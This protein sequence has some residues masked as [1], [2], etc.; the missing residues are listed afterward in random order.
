MDAIAARL[1]G[2]AGA[3]GARG[4]IRVSPLAARAAIGMRGG[5]GE[6]ERCDGRRCEEKRPKSQKPGRP[7]RHAHI[8]AQP[9][10]RHDA[11]QSKSPIFAL[12]LSSNGQNQPQ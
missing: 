10:Q 2:I 8:S 3:A 4:C 7:A 6:E 1:A 5:L 12:S 9:T 11:P